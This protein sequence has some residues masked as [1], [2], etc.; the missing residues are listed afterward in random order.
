MRTSSKNITMLNSFLLLSS[1]AFITAFQQQQGQQLQHNGAAGLFRSQPSS[2]KSSP[3]AASSLTSLSSSSAFF[4]TDDDDNSD[5]VTDVKTLSL[6]T[7]TIRNRLRKATGFSFTVFRKTLRGI[8]GISLTALYA[9]TLAA[10]GLWIRKTMSIFLKLFP[11]GFRYFL[12]PFLILY[13][14]PLILLRTLTG[15][16][17]KRAVDKHNTVIDAWKEAVNV[18]EKLEKDGYSPV[19]VNDEG[20]FELTAPPSLSIDDDNNNN[21]N[22]NNNNEEEELADAMAAVMEI[23]NADDEEKK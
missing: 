1:L 19:S 6:T 8:T 16:S 11:S 5:D 18:A 22:N 20:Y 3:A 4:A 12:Q 7:Q 13:Y 17:R 9:T 21:N 15:P 2:L 10:T 23:K 14:T